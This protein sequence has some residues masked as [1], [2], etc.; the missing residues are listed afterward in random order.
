M[1]VTITMGEASS[2]AE[3][4]KPLAATHSINNIAANTELNT[5]AAFVSVFIVQSVMTAEYISQHCETSCLVKSKP[6]LELQVS[7]VTLVDN[8]KKIEAAKWV[9]AISQSLCIFIHT[10]TL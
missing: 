2:S 8:I 5:N 10:L 9:V 3:L 6:N 7:L 1:S 4:I